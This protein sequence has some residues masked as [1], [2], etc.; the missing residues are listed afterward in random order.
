MTIFFQLT[1]LEK[2]DHFWL[3]R[4]LFDAGFLYFAAELIVLLCQ[5]STVQRTQLQYS[6]QKGNISNLK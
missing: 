5:T 1:D 2:K 6:T 4:P 3:F